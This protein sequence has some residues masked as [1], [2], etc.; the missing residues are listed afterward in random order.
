MRYKLRNLVLQTLYEIDCASHPPEEVVER[1]IEEHSLDPD[2]S[3]FLRHLVIGVS[4]QVERIDERIRAYATEWPVEQLAIID[5]SILRMAIFELAASPDVPVRVIINE[6]VELAKAFGSDAA[7]RFINGVL[8]AIVEKE[9][10][11][12][13]SSGDEK[14][15]SLSS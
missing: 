3:E 10:F 2:N 11:S 13:P 6:A 7:P 14:P 12:T 9:L 1:V 8:G 5:R 4:Q 15:V